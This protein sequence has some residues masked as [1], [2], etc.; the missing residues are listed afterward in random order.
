MHGG[1]AKIFSNRKIHPDRAS[2]KSELAALSEAKPE[3]NRPAK[4]DRSA[5]HGL[6]PILD[7]FC[8]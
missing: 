5:R 7:V 8:K 2:M 6:E 4:I 3:R 1:V